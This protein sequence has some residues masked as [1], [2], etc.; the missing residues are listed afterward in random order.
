MG[1]TVVPDVP[2]VGM[3]CSVSWWKRVTA[4]RRICRMPTEGRE[5]ERGREGGRRV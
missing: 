5:A 1:G 2:M 3:R 4:S